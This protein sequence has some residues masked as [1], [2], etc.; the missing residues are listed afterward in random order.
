PDLPHESLHDRPVRF[1]RVSPYEVPGPF[2]HLEPADLRT[3]T[4]EDLPRRLDRRP[5]I[6]LAHQ[7]QGGTFDS[8][9]LTHDVE[10]AHERNRALVQRRVHH[11]AG[12]LLHGDDVPPEE[13]PDRSPFLA[14]HGAR[15]EVDALGYV[16]ERIT[17][18]S[19][20][21]LDQAP[22]VEARE[23]GIEDEPSGVPWM[24]RRV[25][26]REEAAQ[27]M[28]VDHRLH[29][30]EGVAERAHVVAARSGTPALGIAP[31]GAAVIAHIEVDH[32]GDPGQA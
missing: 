29:D 7:D 24:A 16:G 18:Q 9:E 3:K 5:G 4:I 6:L 11:G 27:R 21:V 2:D 13:L 19:P 30:S 25:L 28:A 26:E 17:A 14:G 15:A 1:G 8:T 10:R 32:L 23:R 22:S 12:T 31:L 20:N